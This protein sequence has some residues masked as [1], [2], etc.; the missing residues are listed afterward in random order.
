[1]SYRLE[2]VG[3]NY[4]KAN[5][6]IVGVL[7]ICENSLDKDRKVETRTHLNKRGETEKPYE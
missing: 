6:I 5:G 3:Q 2:I 4:A 1:M 7:I